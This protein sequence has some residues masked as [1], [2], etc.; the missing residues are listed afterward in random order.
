MHVLQPGKLDIDIHVVE[1]PFNPQV[2]QLNK[3]HPETQIDQGLTGYKLTVEL[4]PNRNKNLEGP[5]SLT[6]VWEIGRKVTMEH[7][8]PQKH[9]LKTRDSF[10][11]KKLFNVK[12]FQ[13]WTSGFDVICVFFLL[14]LRG[15]LDDLTYQISKH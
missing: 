5:G 11:D 9:Y 15:Q 2:Q 10:I 4:L 14:I 7:Y 12:L 3:L 1:Y 8:S 13:N 6:L